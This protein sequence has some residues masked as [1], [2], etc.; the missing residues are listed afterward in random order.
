MALVHTVSMPCDFF[1][2]ALSI[3]F[4][5]V[6]TSVPAIIWNSRRE[7]K[8]SSVIWRSSHLTLCV[9]DGLEQTSDLRRRESISGFFF[10]LGLL[11]GWIAL[12]CCKVIPALRL[13]FV[14]LP[15][16]PRL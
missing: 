9:S 2:F 14:A 8:N 16:R 5:F 15:Y 11:Q 13:E 1:F 3:S 7:N 10:F 6:E 4:F 12:A